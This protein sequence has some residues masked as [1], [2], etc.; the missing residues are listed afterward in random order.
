[1]NIWENFGTFY[2]SLDIGG[3]VVVWGFLF[4]FLFFMVATFLLFSKNRELGKL[5]QEKTKN[6]AE[7]E[8]EKRTL[9][10][11]KIDKVAVKDLNKDIKPVKEKQEATLEEKAIFTDDETD[12][13][14][15]VNKNNINNN[16]SINSKE[17]VSDKGKMIGNV[18]DKEVVI[19]TNSNID[20]KRKEEVKQATKVGQEEIIESPSDTISTRSQ[21]SNNT[22]SSN[23]NLYSRSAL[24]DN[25]RFQTSPIN[26]IREESLDETMQKLKPI[27]IGEAKEDV[28]RENV[29][30]VEEISRKMEQEIKPQTIELTDYELKQEEEAIIS[31]DE[32]MK[33][34]DRLFKITDDEEDDAQFIE[35]LKY[36]R[37]SLQ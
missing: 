16:I 18:T 14:P 19:N 9:L 32:L 35:E 22:V 34:K 2:Q 33:N 13:A 28:K 8:A 27:E 15:V 26:I 10:E 3:L 1:M 6:V 21:V 11:K 36:F 20:D 5:L 31:Y 37:N 17:D 30:F 23:N 4:V 29:N 12:D 24:K 25:R 7:L